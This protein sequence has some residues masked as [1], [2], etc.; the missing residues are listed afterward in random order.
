MG[1]GVG[2]GV[3]LD[4]GL[5]VGLGV[6]LRVGDE[7]GLSVSWEQISDLNSQVAPSAWS[8]RPAISVS[9]RKH[10]PSVSSYVNALHFFS[11][12]HRDLQ[13]EME[14]ASN[15]VTDSPLHLYP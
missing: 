7:V 2:A 8:P 6:G 3:G 13:L 1:L 14:G 11:S 10:C 9:C 15:A 12:L 5:E 4:V